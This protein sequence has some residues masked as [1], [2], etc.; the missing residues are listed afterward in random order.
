MDAQ[1]L[2]TMKGKGWRLVPS[3]ASCTY[4]I[5]EKR[6]RRHGGWGQCL[7]IMY[8]HAK[9]GP[10]SMPSH[11]LAVCDLYQPDE[12]VWSL[13]ADYADTFRTEETRYDRHR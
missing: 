2:K 3:C 8:M 1:K 4:A 9:H 7:K 11:M 13:L 12:S 6:L 5:P 10:R